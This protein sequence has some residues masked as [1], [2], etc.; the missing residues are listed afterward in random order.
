MGECR[1]CPR[2]AKKERKPATGQPCQRLTNR[3]LKGLLPER[4]EKIDPIERRRVRMIA[5]ALAALVSREGPAWPLSELKLPAELVGDL[6]DLGFAERWTGKDGKE[7]VAL[8]QK[9]ADLARRV[10]SSDG[11]LRDAEVS[12]TVAIARGVPWVTP[13]RK[14]EGAA[15]YA[16]E[17]A[18]GGDGLFSQA[19]WAT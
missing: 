5:R 19:R 9:A 12:R 13:Y 4:P 7:L 15:D 10:P 14:P 17:L 18:E 11:G 1:A 2:R 6:V 16:R 3:L 8:T